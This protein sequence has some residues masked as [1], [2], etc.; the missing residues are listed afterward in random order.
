MNCPRL[1]FPEKRWKLQPVKALSKQPVAPVWVWVWVWE[2]SLRP[3][4]LLGTHRKAGRSWLGKFWGTYRE[5][6]LY[7]EDRAALVPQ[8]QGDATSSQSMGSE[9]EWRGQAGRAWVTG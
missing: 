1:K 9:R 3:G 6:R 4:A 7:A 8:D 5:D 2:G